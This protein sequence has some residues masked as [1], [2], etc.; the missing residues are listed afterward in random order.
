MFNPWIQYNSEWSFQI[1]RLLGE[2]GQGGGEAHE[3]L[4]LVNKIRL[5]NVED[6]YQEFS[7]LAGETEMKADGAIAKGHRATARNHYCRATSYY[8][9]A[10]LFLDIDDSRK[11]SNYQ[12][13]ISCF[14][15]AAPFFS[16][17]IESVEIKFEGASLPGYFALPHENSRTKHP[18]VLY[19]AGVDVLKEILFFLGGFEALSR[20]LALLVMDGPGQGETLRLKEIPSRH[21]Y[22][23]P[24]AAA[25]DYLEQ[26]SEVDPT[27]IAIVGRS[28]GGYYGA[29]AAAF[30]KR[31]KACVL[32]GAL[33]D[34]V[35]FYETYRRLSER[36]QRHLHWL[37][38]A[39]DEMDARKQFAK[40]NLAGVAE[41]IT[42]PTLVIHA[43]G[44]TFVP[45]SHAYR[46]F[47]EISGPKQQ[48]IIES[49]EPGSVHCQY[50]NFPEILP[51]I[52]DWVADELA[53]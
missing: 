23:R 6:W 30:E 45:V 32:F 46:V 36:R 29:R 21:D 39:K 13:S 2:A 51:F 47:S 53:K 27:K 43:K 16:P 8:R 50:D 42:C 28:F 48:R 37:V 18:A 12:K 40:F 25:V 31:I 33:Y 38:G 41:R 26:R 5:G 34:A 7:K 44:D 10:D 19:V 49:G 11:L 4:R 14:K 17:S 52:F 35:D 3:L 20:G 22:E 24:V 15:R 9:A 1:T